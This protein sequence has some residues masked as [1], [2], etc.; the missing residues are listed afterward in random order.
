MKTL[1]V[2]RASISL[3]LLASGCGKAAP[4]AQLGETRDTTAMEGDTTVKKPRRGLGD[5]FTIPEPVDEDAEPS[6]EGGT[7]DSE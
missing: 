2:V 3:L 4:K 6:Q 7:S 5:M 1:R